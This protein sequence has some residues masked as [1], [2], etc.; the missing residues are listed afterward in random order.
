MQLL[1]KTAVVGSLANA[2]PPTIVA[3]VSSSGN[4]AT[5]RRAS[6]IN[7]SPRRVNDNTGFYY[8]QT[9]LANTNLNFIGVQFDVRSTCP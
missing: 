3:Q 4:N 2:T 8:L 9:S 7:I 1:R 6:T 5:I